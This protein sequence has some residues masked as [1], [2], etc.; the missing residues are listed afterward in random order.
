MAGGVDNIDLKIFVVDASMF[1]KD[2]DS[3]LFFLVIAI[4]DSL[5]YFFVF[6]ENVSLFKQVV[7]KGCFPVVNVS[8]NCDISDFLW[9][10]HGDNDRVASN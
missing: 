9:V 6:A 8:N 10:V 5:R 1:R 4:H 7:E 2:S 3:A